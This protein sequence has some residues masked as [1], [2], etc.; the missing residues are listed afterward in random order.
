MRAV[1]AIA[2]EVEEAL[3][4]GRPVVALE[5]TL[6][7]HGLP[8]PQGFEVA[9]ELERILRE[10]GAIPATIAILGGQARIGVEATD[11]GRLV[12][13]GASKVNLGNL[14]A[15]LAS[16]G[17]GSTTVAATMALAHRAGIPVFATGGIGGVHRGVIDSGDVSADLTAMVRYPVAVV[18]AGAKALLDL[19][20]TVEALETGG[21]PVLGY[22]T[23]EFPAFYR[24]K[25]GLAVDL[26]CDSLQHL[27]DVVATHFRLDR[28]PTGVLV[29]NPIPKD[30]EMSRGVY[31]GALAQ[32]LE[33]LESEGVQGR[34]VTPF[35]LG[36]LDQITAGTSVSVNRALLENNVRLAA[37][38]AG[39]LIRRVD[40]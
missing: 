19:P 25:S 27:A 3:A 40:K 36:K 35:L 37:R 7:T 15:V 39:E 16:G 24:R 28:Q 6:V 33:A 38:L 2:P 30:A 8:H 18:C 14:A 23:D 22:R 9:V 21:V 29:A 11:L 1:L 4:G 5:T 13:S 20:K 34:D 12:S 17:A 31:D 26:R 32:A 10:E